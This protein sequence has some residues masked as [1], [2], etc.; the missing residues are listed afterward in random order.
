MPVTVVS[1]PAD[2]SERTSRAGLVLGDLGGPSR[3]LA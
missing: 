2:S 1:T 3:S